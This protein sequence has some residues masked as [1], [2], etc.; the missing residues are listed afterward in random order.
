MHNTN[1]MF[2]FKQGQQYNTCMHN[3]VAIN[4]ITI[5]Y[6]TTILAVITVCVIIG[7]MSMLCGYIIINKSHLIISYMI[8]LQAIL[9]NEVKLPAAVHIL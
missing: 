5:K 9:M 4:N 2:F 6:A 7:Q 3:S 8:T 1:C